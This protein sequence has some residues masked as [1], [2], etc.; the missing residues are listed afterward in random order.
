MVNLK[1]RWHC[2]HSAS[3]LL[4]INKFASILLKLAIVNFL[5]QENFSAIDTWPATHVAHT[6]P[7]AVQATL[8]PNANVSYEKTRH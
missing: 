1:I 8:T 4:N 7:T 5:P 6:A 2:F 3:P